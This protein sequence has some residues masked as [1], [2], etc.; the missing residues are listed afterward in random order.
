MRALTVAEARAVDEDAVRRLS[1]PTLLLMENAAR[2]VAEEARR[3]GSRFVVFC[4]PGNNGGDGL[5]A[6]RHLGPSCEV[7]CFSEPDPKRAPDA[8]LQFRILMAA[9]RPP[10]VGPPPGLSSRRGAVWIDALFGIG[11][12][13]PI[14][15]RA[16]AYVEAFN[17]AEGPKLSVDVPSGLDGDSGEALGGVA[18]RAD[19]VVTFVAPK[20]GLL[21]RAAAPYVGRVVV[22]GLGLP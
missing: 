19:V 12:T 6:A 17:A 15:G 7:F 14:E 13:R 11:L 1:M 4:G 3:L 20:V 21:Q 22:A 10:I 16:R 8:A 2:S 5:A 9:G 18:C